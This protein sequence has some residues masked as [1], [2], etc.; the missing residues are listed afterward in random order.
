MRKTCKSSIKNYTTFSPNRYILKVP[1]KIL[2]P[3]CWRFLLPQIWLFLFYLMHFW[4]VSVYFCVLHVYLNKFLFTRS[5]QV[6]HR[7]ATTTWTKNVGRSNIRIFLYSDSRYTNWPSRIFVIYARVEESLTP[8]LFRYFWN[9][10]KFFVHDEWTV[11]KVVFEYRFYLKKGISG[12]W[13]FRFNFEA[14]DLRWSKRVRVNTTC[15][16]V[17][18]SN[19]FLSWS[20]ITF[21]QNTG[22]L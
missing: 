20:R 3:P 12:F 19:F 8:V 2:G 1:S 18:F 4:L 11:R 21:W 6:S 14:L 13:S 16:P 7:H 15:N 22:V 10:E 9:L 17:Y 5:G